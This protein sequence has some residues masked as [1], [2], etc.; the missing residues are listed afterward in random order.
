MEMDMNRLFIIGT[1]L[2]IIGFI[3][4]IIGSILPAITMPSKPSEK[5]EVGVGGCI[6]IMFIP[7]CFGYGKPE[8]MTP[9]II[10]SLA[11][12]IILAVI[13]IIM[14]RKIMTLSIEKR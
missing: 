10:L 7:I 2:I 1:T 14:T 9:L 4:I 13:Y 3:V 8:I 6:V 11:L 12:V 5:T